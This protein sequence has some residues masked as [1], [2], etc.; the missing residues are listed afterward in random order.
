MRIAEDYAGQL[1][2]AVEAGIAFKGS[3]FRAQAQAERNGLTLRQIEEQQ[4]IAAARLAQIYW[5]LASVIARGEIPADVRTGDFAEDKINTFCDAL[6]EQAEPIQALG[7]QAA[8]ACADKQKG[9]AAGW[10]NDVCVAP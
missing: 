8:G 6:A 2:R 3:A 9:V 10:W 4:R 1:T 5:R 7:E